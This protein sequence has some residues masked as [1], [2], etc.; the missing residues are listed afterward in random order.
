MISPLEGSYQYE[1]RVLIYV[2]HFSVISLGLQECAKLSFFNTSARGLDF[3]EEIIIV[4]SDSIQTVVNVKYY[5]E[6]I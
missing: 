6:Y 5:R 4:G 2:P 3:Y 1:I